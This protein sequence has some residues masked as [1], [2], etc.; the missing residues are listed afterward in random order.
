MISAPL[1]TGFELERLLLCLRRV[2]TCDGLSHQNVLLVRGY[3]QEAF[4]K[5]GHW[6]GI[7]KNKGRFWPDAVNVEVL[8]IT[9][10]S[11]PS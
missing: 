1:F 9:S 4:R 5:K 3:W 10:G 11:V 8:N 2:L 7:L 6:P